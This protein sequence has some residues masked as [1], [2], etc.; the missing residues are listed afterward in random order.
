MPCFSAS[1]IVDYVTKLL[2]HKIFLYSKTYWWLQSSFSLH[3]SYLLIFVT[4]IFISY[5]CLNYNILICFDNNN[6]P[7]LSRQRNHDFW[8][9]PYF[10]NTVNI[11]CQVILQLSFFSVLFHTW[12]SCPLKFMY[13][14]FNKAIVLRGWYNKSWLYHENFAFRIGKC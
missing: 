14:K 8:K 6:N 5:S 10:Q 3:G 2:E 11:K 4:L 13:W 12:N 1:L 9:W 7:I